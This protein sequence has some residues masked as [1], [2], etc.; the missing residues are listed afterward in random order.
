LEDAFLQRIGTAQG[1]R[2]TNSGTVSFAWT[3]D[4]NT[5]YL[6]SDISLPPL[7]QGS[8]YIPSSIIRN[9]FDLNSPSKLT[10]SNSIVTNNTYTRACYFQLVDNVI[11]IVYDDIQSM[12]TLLSSVT[13]QWVSRSDVYH[14][15]SVDSEINQYEFLQINFP[16]GYQYRLEL[17]TY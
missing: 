16:L 10:I 2:H 4:Q 13:Y 14:R 5:S 6:V 12:D 9:I 7:V 8:M 17:G 11:S 3:Y 1:T 15:K